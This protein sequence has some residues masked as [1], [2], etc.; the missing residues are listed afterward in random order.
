MRELHSQEAGAWAKLHF[1]GVKLNDPR[2]G[3]RLATLARG[4]AEN[5]GESVPRL[6]CK[7]SEVKAAYVFFDRPEVTPEAIQAGHRALVYEQLRKPGTYLLIEDSSEFSWPEASA[8]AGLGMMRRQRQGFVLHTS[9]AAVWEK[10]R[11][12]E[13]RRG[14]LRLLGLAHQEFYPR[15]ARPAGEA[16]KA[17]QAR[18][19]RARESELWRRSTQTLGPA[20]P[21]GGGALGPGG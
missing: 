11:A 16:D 20:P 19:K 3:R 21:R 10:P 14:A 6:F 9:L 8:R 18:R 13:V 2:R 15:A 17:S 7:V 4:Y 1:G 12:A 5:P